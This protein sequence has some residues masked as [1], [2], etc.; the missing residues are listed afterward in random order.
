MELDERS[1]I[2]VDVPDKNLMMFKVRYR[3]EQELR[4]IWIKNIDNIENRKKPLTIIIREL[5]DN[6]IIDKQLYYILREVLSICNYAIHGENVSQSQVDFV[7]KNAEEIIN[8]LSRM[9]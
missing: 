7:E 9:E 1:K 3:I 4:R 8:Y 6:Q 5:T 2:K